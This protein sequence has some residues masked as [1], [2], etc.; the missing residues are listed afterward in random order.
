MNK[1]RDLETIS[2]LQMVIRFSPFDEQ[3]RLHRPMVNKTNQF[4][5]TTRRY[6]E[7]E[8]AALQADDS[9]FTLQ[10]RLADKFG[11]LGMIG[12]VI[13][14][15]ANDDRSTWEIDSWL[16]S[17]RVLGRQVEQAM[18]AKVAG[19]ARKRGVHR[20]MGLYI[21][22]A[23]NGMVA[24]HY[25][26]LGFRRIGNLDAAQSAWEL[27]VPAYVAPALSMLITDDFLPE[28][29]AGTTESRRLPGVAPLAD[30]QAAPV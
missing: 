18:L 24:E 17:C 10:V 14:R 13:C 29:P 30:G 9:V 22:T 3:G 6:T 28:T 1:A 2:S 20:L 15:Q 5:L 25:G 27:D 8:V 7:R 16:M 4:N 26:R 11:D 21:P 23:K 12:V 19:E